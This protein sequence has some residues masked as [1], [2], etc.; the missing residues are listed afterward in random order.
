MHFI[1]D[2]NRRIKVFHCKIIGRF[3]IS[4]SIKNK[5]SYFLEKEC[6]CSV[7]VEIKTYTVTNGLNYN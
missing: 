4:F 2:R 5:K 7:I 3:T 1:K 6:N